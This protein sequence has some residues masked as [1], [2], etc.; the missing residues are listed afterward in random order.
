M[1]IKLIKLN[2]SCFEGDISSIDDSIIRWFPLIKSPIFKRFIHVLFEI[3]DDNTSIGY[4]FKTY[5]KGVF[6]KYGKYDI[7]I[8]LFPEFQSKGYGKS[9]IKRLYQIDKD[10]FFIVDDKNE[11]MLNVLNTIKHTKAIAKE[12]KY[13]IFVFYTISRHPNI[14]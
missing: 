2:P 5:A 8:L 3:M 9:V 7:S 4:V 1:N 14:N 6:Q 12:S 10:V 13:T 11:R